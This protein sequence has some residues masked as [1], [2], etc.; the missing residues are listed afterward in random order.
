MELYV[1]VHALG[2]LATQL[3][4]IKQALESAADLPDTS[5][6]GYDRINGAVGDFVD[7]WRDG[8]KKII[9][10]I[11]AQIARINA[12]V[13]TYQENERAIKAACT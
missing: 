5:G 4:Q 2:Q 7:G 9:K 1:D 11:D 6:L 8:R 12:A 3:Q 10:G 13:S